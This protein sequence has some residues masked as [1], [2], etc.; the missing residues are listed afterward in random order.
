M[1]RRL[2]TASAVVGLIMTTPGIVSADTISVTSPISGW[3]LASTG[4][5]TKAGGTVAINVGAIVNLSHW[6]ISIHS[7]KSRMSEFASNAYVSG[8]KTLGAA[9]QVVPQSGPTGSCTVNSQQTVTVG[10]SDG[11]LATGPVP[12]VG[13]CT[14]TFTINLSQTTA[15]TDPA[16]ATGHTYHLVLTYTLATA[17]G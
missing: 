15:I 14:K 8:G 2:L 13:S 5:N 11:T 17:L 10:T 4:S 3:N 6:T 16:L 9:L 1:R 12:L 7:D